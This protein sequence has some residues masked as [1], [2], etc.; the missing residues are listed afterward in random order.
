MGH[1]HW[2]HRP[3]GREEA[4]CWHSLLPPPS[5]DT[6][7]RAA[8]VCPRTWTA[9]SSFSPWFP[10]PAAQMVKNPLATQETQA[11]SLGWEDPLEKGMAIHSSFL[12]WRIPQTGD[13]GGLQSMGCKELDMTEHF[14]FHLF[15]H[16][17]PLPTCLLTWNSALSSYFHPQLQI[18]PQ[19]IRKPPVF[20]AG[21]RASLSLPIGCSWRISLS[22]SISASAH[23]LSSSKSPRHRCAMENT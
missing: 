15:P 7:P 13:P 8:P 11:Q 22:T 12:A 14:H 2:L 21:N 18:T 23:S 3:W 20:T 4:Q 1:L 10:S 17:G 16:L 5:L 9:V 19:T 6:S